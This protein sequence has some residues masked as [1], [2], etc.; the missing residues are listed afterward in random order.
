MQPPHLILFLFIL[1]RLPGMWADPEE[2]LQVFQVFQTSLFTGAAS[3]TV[4]RVAL[5]GDVPVFTLDPANWTIQF[6]WPWAR[7]AAGE[8]DLEKI[9]SHSKLFLRNEIRYVDDLVQQAQWSY[10]FLVQM[11]A[12]CVLHPNR[13]TQGFIDI[14]EDGRDLIAFDTERHRWEPLQ[15]SHVADVVRKSLMSMK[16][17]TE[18]LEHIISISCKNSILILWKY[19]KAT[20]ERQEMPVATVFA[21]TSRPDQLLLVCRVTGFYP[22]PISVAWLRDGQEVPPGPALN[23]STILP[24]ADLTYQLRS[25]LA[26]APCD[27]HSYACRVRHRSLGTRSLLIPWVPES[28]S[29]APTLG[30]TIAL[31]LIVAA[32]SAGMFWWWK[33]R[34]GN[35]ATQDTQEFIT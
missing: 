28:C 23:T 12:G 1:L 10:P 8:G 29:T 7:Q 9:M 33:H 24:N 2:E 30:I 26:V 35:G 25:V 11:R 16:S 22:R 18:L 20:L 17:V 15:Q 13:T 31:L 4:S 14:G 19:G 6:H 27:G 3:A 21:R 34:K 32:A 5:L